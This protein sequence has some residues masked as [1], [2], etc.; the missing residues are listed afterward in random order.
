MTWT[1]TA[2]KGKQR[3][4]VWLPTAWILLDFDN[5]CS[6]IYESQV[7]TNGSIKCMGFRGGCEL[8][9]KTAGKPGFG[10]ASAAYK[11]H[12]PGPVLLLCLP[13]GSVVKMTWNNI[14]R[15]SSSGEW[16]TENRPSRERGK[17]PAPRWRCL[18]FA[19]AQAGTTASR[20]PR[21]RQWCFFHLPLD[22]GWVRLFALG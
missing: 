10:S 5:L 16:S 6:L 12:D 3:C 20:W 4:V 14:R 18:S 22:G 7:R 19:G 8:L 15:V 2:L 13:Q 17:R 11:P 9:Q 21:A 1:G